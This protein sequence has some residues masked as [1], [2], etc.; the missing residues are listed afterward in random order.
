[1]QSSSSSSPTVVAAAAA[2]EELKARVEALERSRFDDDNNDSSSVLPTT[3]AT[4]TG[5]VLFR[6]VNDDSMRR[7]RSRV[8]ELGIFSACWKFVPEPYYSW[9][10][11]KRA[12]CLGAQ[13][14][15]HLCKS[16]L[17]E[18]RKA[19][20]P[21]EGDPDPTNPRF[22]LVVI[23]YAA[24]L[25]VKKLANTVRALRKDVKNRLD[26]S[27]FD[28]R[29]ASEDDNRSITGFEHNSVTPF[30]ILKP[31]PIVVSAAL[32]PLR[33]FWLGGGHVHLKLGMS[34]AEFCRAL[35]P[36]VA[37]ISRPRTALELTQMCESDL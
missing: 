27:Q 33:S 17:M 5:A 13:S 35:N 1:M 28:W 21:M 20:S 30:G 16:L 32:A 18:N 6:V 10:L 9:P 23:Q 3:T 7:A 12:D 26:E 24:T 2:I 8:E 36:I 14:I 19:A 37:D 4:T 25:D 34:F 15:Q 11:E 31:V 22:V 29:I